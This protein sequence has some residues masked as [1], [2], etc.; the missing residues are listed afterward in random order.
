MFKLDFLENEGFNG[1]IS[2]L[3]FDTF[4]HDTLYTYKMDQKFLPT[5][6]FFFFFFFNKTSKYKF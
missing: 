4:L 2:S 6:F 3:L 5:Y 1:E